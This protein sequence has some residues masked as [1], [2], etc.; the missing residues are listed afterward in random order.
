MLSCS[1]W[2]S[3]PSFWMGGDLESRCV[4]RVCVQVVPCDRANYSSILIPLASNQHNL[5][6]I[7]LLL[8]VQCWTPDDGQRCCP[9]HVEF[10]SKNKFEKLVHLFGFVTRRK[11]LS[12]YRG[13]VCGSRGC[14]ATD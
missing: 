14:G 9:K 10:H 3:A 2:F 11:S 13:Q 4:G 5:Y 12:K 1:I 6:D 7:Y 8:C